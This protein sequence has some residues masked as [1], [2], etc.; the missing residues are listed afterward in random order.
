MHWLLKKV[1][2]KLDHKIAYCMVI[3]SP[4]LPNR[5]YEFQLHAK[6]YAHVVGIDEVGRG[7]WA[8]P[9]V[10]GACILKP[11]AQ[12]ERI[13]D[14]K[15][16]SPKQRDYYFDL[17]Q[18]SCL[19]YGLGWVTAA[20]IDAI[21][22]TRGTVVATERAIA[23]MQITPHYALCDYMPLPTVDYPIE[24]FVR[25]DNTITAIAAASVVAKVSRDRFMQE[26]SR[27]YDG[28]DF[29]HNVGYPSPKH[30]AALGTL[31]PSP[32]HRNLFLRKFRSRTQQDAASRP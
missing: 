28:Y 29:I 4:K 13:R 23:A 9:L 16:L 6:G 31:G 15:L 12:L 20:E 22:L 5:N 8:G 7:A 25:G 1:T 27:Q 11:E 14:S 17:V 10:V 26:Q 21:G 24:R 32:L 19:A 2:L 30:L 3:M 18:E